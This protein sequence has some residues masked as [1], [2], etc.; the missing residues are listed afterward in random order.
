M[1]GNAVA[2]ARTQL[3][4]VRRLIADAGCGHSWVAIN[5]VDTTSPDNG[6]HNITPFTQ[7]LICVLNVA[8][9]HEA[10]LPMG[11][12]VVHLICLS[13]GLLGWLGGRMAW[14]FSLP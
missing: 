14:R 12:I 8:T 13:G 9:H 1:K 7:P 2:A 3:G 4:G 5:G 11:H 10:E 6:P